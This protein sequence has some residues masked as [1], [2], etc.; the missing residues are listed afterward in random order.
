MEYSLKVVNHC[1]TPETYNIVHELYHSF[2]KSILALVFSI[3]LY[4]TNV[5]SFK[6]ILISLNIANHRKEVV[7]YP[8]L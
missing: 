3:V 7:L 4:Y 6:Q 2:F 1:C 8:Y 5:L